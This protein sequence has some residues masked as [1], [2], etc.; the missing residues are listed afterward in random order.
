MRYVKMNGCGNDFAIFDAR[1]SSPARFSPAQVKS[2]ADRTAGVG[3]DQVI[4]LES[5]SHADAIMRIWNAD[6]AE[7][8]ACG[9]GARC[10]A[11]LLMQEGGDAK[12]IETA[13]GRLS[14]RRRGPNEVE[15]NFGPPRLDWRE[16]PVAEA[17]DTVRL[18][19]GVEAAGRRLEGPGAVNMGNPHAVFFVRAIGDVPIGV[20]GPLVERDSLFPQGVNVGFAEIQAGDAVRLRVWERGVGLTRACGT[21]ACAAVVAAHR[22]GLLER[23]ARVIVDGGTLHVHWGDDGHVRLA[24]PVQFEG[25]GQFEFR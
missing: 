19:Y 7:V 16:I 5:S 1:R 14:A 22:L 15:I 2:I 4:A 9:N 17:M 8:G 21:G 12:L 20:F 10:A 3:C 11:W 18:P 25:S 13:G 24:G 6:G 23:E